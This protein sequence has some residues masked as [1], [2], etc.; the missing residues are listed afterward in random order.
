MTTTPYDKTQY[1]HKMNIKYRKKKPSIHLGGREP[2]FLTP[3]KLSAASLIAT[4]YHV[5]VSFLS[6]HHQIR[7]PDIVLFDTLWKIRNPIGGTIRSVERQV[8]RSLPHSGSIIFDARYMRLDRVTI[9][10]EL[11]RLVKQ[12]AGIIR[13]LILIE[14]GGTVIE[15]R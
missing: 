9:R 3:L 2:L 7:T 15:L 12:R 4:H 14:K 5:D 10:Q 11:E 6:L 1:Y 8:K 13:H